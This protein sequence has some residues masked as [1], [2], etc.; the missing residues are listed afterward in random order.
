MLRKLLTAVG[1]LG[2]T[3]QAM[4]SNTGLVYHEAE[5]RDEI[6]RRVTSITSVTIYVTGTTNAQVIYQDPSRTLAITQPMTTSSTNTTLV[7]GSFYWYGADPWDFTVTDGTNVHSNV[8]HATL[9]ASVGRIIFPSYITSINTT[10][11]TDGQTQT[12]GTDSDWVANGGGTAD[13]MTW[14]PKTADTAEFWVGSTNF[15]ANLELFGATST[16]DLRWDASANAFEWDD[17]AIASWGDSAD[18]TITHGGSTTNFGGAYTSDAIA[19]FATDVIFDGTNN[20]KFDDSRFQLHFQD[21]AILGIGGAADAVGDVTMTHDGSDFYLD[22]AIADEGWL[23]GDTTTGFDQDY[24]FETAG[25]IFTDYDG[26]YRAFMDDM[27]LRFGTG[28]GTKN[29]D[30]M[31][32]GD[33]APLLTIDVVVAGTGEIAVGNDADD[34]PLKWFGETT[35]DFAYFTGDQL[36]LE[37][38]DLSLGDAT[39]LLFGDALGTGDIK[40]YAT[41]TDLIIDGVVAE[42][43]TVAIGVTDLGIDFKLWAATSAEGVLWDASDEALEFT[44]ANVTLDAASVL[45]LGQTVNADVVVTD[46]ATYTVLAVNSGKVHM[47]A[48]LTQNT[49]IDLPAEADGLHYRFIYIGGA[50]ETHDHTIDSQNNTNFFIGGTAFA[51]IDA[52][53]AADEIHVGLYSDGNSNSKLT[54]N[55]A[56]AGTMID[57]HCD[58]TNWYVRGVVFSDTAPAFA[59]Q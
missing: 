53:D 39:L 11:F 44:G 50:A 35:G 25:S 45:T 21:D 28:G 29:G 48:D 9:T 59:D 56:S 2:L 43:G 18:F 12:F 30:F 37:D 27:D 4:A 51:D 47:I 7:N 58:G 22:A 14:I 52:G 40:V 6:N 42:T 41:G 54:I 31:I 16:Y 34:V 15:P 19:T 55:N 32:S 10:S 23:I 3:V 13:R 1:V 36:Q 24:R 49:D 5:V 38:I 57:I 20:I 26:D 17:N 46:A 8:G 33:S